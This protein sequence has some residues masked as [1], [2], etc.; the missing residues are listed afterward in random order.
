[1]QFTLLSDWLSDCFMMEAADQTWD[2]V[3]LAMYHDTDDDT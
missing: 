1:M 3:Q 2:L